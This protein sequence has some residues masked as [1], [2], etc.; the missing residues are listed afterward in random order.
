M[1]TQTA[2][3]SAPPRRLARS[4][5]AVVAGFVAVV[6]LSLATDQVMHVVNVYPPWGQPMRDPGLLLLALG[7]RSIYNVVGG[8]LAARLAPGE[9]MR[10]AIALASS[11]PSWAWPERSPRSRWT[12][13]RLGIRSGSS[14]WRSPGPGSAARC[15]A[16]DSPPRGAGRSQATRDHDVGDATSRRASRLHLSV[17]TVGEMA[18]LGAMLSLVFPHDI[19]RVPLSVFGVIGGGQVVG[20][21]VTAERPSRPLDHAEGADAGTGRARDEAVDA[22]VP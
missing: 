7:Y 8:F 21:R 22:T 19:L 17:A 10:H 20:S 5:A 3:L 6:V 13:A 16:D 14:S 9:P 12:S 18:S 15:T 11:D 1:T 4:I 2:T